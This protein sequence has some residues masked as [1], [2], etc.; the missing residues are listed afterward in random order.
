LEAC[1]DAM[2]PFGVMP[3]S[4]VFPRNR[5]EYSLL[6]VIAQAGITVVRHRDRAGNI[7]LGYPERT[8][9]GVYKIYESMNL[10][11]GKYYDCLTKAKI[12]IEKAMER[13]AAY[14]FWFHPSDPFEAFDT[15]FRSILRYIDSERQ[16]G[17][18][19][20]TTMGDLAAYCEAREQIMLTPVR[21]DKTL[22]ISIQTALDTS[23][24]GRPKLTLVVPISSAPK[25]SWL[26]L[27]NG[28]RIEVNA[29]V[30]SKNSSRQLLVD[31]PID[32]K[33]LVFSF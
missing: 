18:V 27:N 14:S 28:E 32:A 20:I 25:S 31:V 26:G 21:Q 19:W 30:T 11:L 10:R 6:P 7:K 29:R 17:R 2:R 22:K 33:T 16:R 1:I 13:R 15:Q 24:Y 3:R 12:F 4:L 8:S 23:R 5:D 9:S